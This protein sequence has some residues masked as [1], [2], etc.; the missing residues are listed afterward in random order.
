ME[1][2]DK[3]AELTGIMLGDGCLSDRSNRYHIYISG[4]KQDDFEY[5]NIVIKELFLNLFDKKVNVNKRSDE[6]TLFIRFSDKAIFNF[7]KNLGIPVGKK[8]NKLKIPKFVKNTKYFAPFIRGLVDT[9]GCVVFSKQHRLVKYYPRIEITSKSREFLIQNLIHLKKLNF[10][11]SVS[12]KGGGYRLEIPGF[13]NLN[14][15]MKLIG[16]NNPKHIKKIGAYAPNALDQTRI[17]QN[18]RFSGDLVVS[19]L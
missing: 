9:D 4:H 1:K 13:K 18:L 7:F 11:G 19:N 15:W 6:N 3:L 5:H 14:R 8:Y 10:Y 12:F 16:F 17:H 2:I